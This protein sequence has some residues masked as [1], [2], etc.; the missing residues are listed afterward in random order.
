MEFIKG[1]SWRPYQIE[2]FGAIHKGLKE[3]IDKQLVVQATGLGKRIQAVYLS[4]KFNKTLFLAH[5]EELIMQAF[6]DF[7]EAHGFGNVGIIKGPRFEVGKK[8]V[9][10]SPATLHNRL[11]KIDHKCFDLVIIDEAHHYL[12]KTFVK[13]VNHFKPRLR[14]GLTATPYRLDGL[15][16]SN[17]ATKIIHEYNIDEGI[18]D[19][20][21]A[22]LDAVKIPTHI[23]LKG[24]KKQGGDLNM[25]DLSAK[26]DIP[27]RNALV[28]EKYLQHA[29]GRQAIVFATTVEHCKNLKFH[30]DMRNISCE[31][32]VGDTSVTPDRDG[33]VSRFK[34]GKTQ[35]LININIATE[36]FDY[37]DVGAVLLARPTMSL[38]LYMQMVGRGTR[39]K[40][41][42]YIATFNTNSCKVIDFVDNTGNHNLINAWELDRKL[43]AKDKV[44][45]TEE[46]REKLLEAER[47]R[48]EREIKTRV[49]REV[50]VDLLKLPEYKVWDSPRMQEEATDKQIDFLR[51]LGVYEEGVLY[52]KQMASEAISNQPAS[53]WQKRQLR[54]WGYDPEGATIGHF[55]KVKNRI[56]NGPDKF[57]ADENEVIKKIKS[58]AGTNL[59][60]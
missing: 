6:D 48:Q 13:C 57:K 28:A 11:D 47:I 34:S 41:E 53:G 37:N 42:D 46:T 30:F 8:I 21:L 27:A 54:E 44:F 45:L 55:G 31:I 2:C 38:A 35:A 60:F 23:D 22:P 43:P 10:A 9:I 19:G 14:V 56:E 36:G 50:S 20:Y 51:K 40:T 4:T 1:I 17:I 49:D 59:P 32:L 52:T 3:G 24:V 5:N 26:V 58:I 16:L 29:K 7:E 18:R 33:V 39:L 25:K 15:Q 12:A